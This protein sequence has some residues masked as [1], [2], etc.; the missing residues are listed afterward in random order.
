MALVFVLAQQYGSGMA[1]EAVIE[2]DWDLVASLAADLHDAH[3]RLV[4]L[5]ERVL[6]EGSWQAGGIRSPEHWLMVRAGL[7][8]GQA[9]A[10][11]LI[12]RRASELPSTSAAL[13]DGRISLDQAAIVA[14]HTPAAFDET[15]AAFAQ[16][17]TVTQLHRTVSRYD[18]TLEPETFDAEGR[19]LPGARHP[20]AAPDLVEPASLS[21]GIEEDGRFRLRYE[22][23]AEVGALVRA[24]LAEAK[25]HLFHTLG[26]AGASSQGASFDE[27]AGGRPRVT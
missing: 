20:D 5:V 14:R 13:H 1:S 25:D 16:F 19:L 10:M 21:M 24:A 6:D 2:Q 27:A 8:R 4:Q 11:V 12:A 9:R 23:P 26:P 22:A 3:A 17:A 18:F 15:V 7:S